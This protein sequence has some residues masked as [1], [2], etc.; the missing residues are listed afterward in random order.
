MF[1][2]ATFDVY[3]CRGSTMTSSQ[4][5][6]HTQ[7]RSAHPQVRM[8]SQKINILQFTVIK[9]SSNAHSRSASILR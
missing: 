6:Q 8:A 9:Y 2:C 1:I 5:N 7:S 4:H 3:A